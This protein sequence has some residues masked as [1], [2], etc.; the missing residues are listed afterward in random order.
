MNYAAEICDWNQIIEIAAPAKG[1]SLHHWHLA[2]SSSGRDVHLPFQIPYAYA[3]VTKI[4]K[5][6]KCHPNT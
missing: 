2:K 4:C 6:Q 5:Q 1:V 3:Y